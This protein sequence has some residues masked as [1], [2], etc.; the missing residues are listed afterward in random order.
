[1]F[2]FF[3]IFTDVYKDAVVYIELRQKLGSSFVTSFRASAASKLMRDEIPVV[4][5]SSTE[6]KGTND[7]PEAVSSS[8]V[9]ASDN[10][11]FEASDS[12]EPSPST[13]IQKIHYKATKHDLFMKIRDMINEVSELLDDYIKMEF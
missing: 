11:I 4:D 5:V 9:T 3:F 10:E 8:T 13:V 1:M 7:L 2:F 6:I 12:S